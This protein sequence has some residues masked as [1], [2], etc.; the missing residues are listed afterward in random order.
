[1]RRLPGAQG[2]SATPSARPAWTDLATSGASGTATASVLIPMQ[3]VPQC[4]S[5]VT[6]AAVPDRGPNGYM[7]SSSAPATYKG[8]GEPG[9]LLVTK[10]EP[11]SMA[12]KNAVVMREGSWLSTRASA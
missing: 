12:P 9:T 8:N 10:S 1:R 11:F 3:H 5:S 6:L 7:R 4:E 2:P